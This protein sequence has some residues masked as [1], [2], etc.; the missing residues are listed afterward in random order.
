LI[1]VDSNGSLPEERISSLRRADPYRFI[2]IIIVALFSL[3][4]NLGCGKSPPQK[5]RELEFVLIEPGVFT[6]GGG[7]TYSL[8][9]HEVKITKRFYIGMTE[10]T[11]SQWY[12]VM[13][14]QPWDTRA[15]PDF[16]ATGMDW[17][18]AVEFCNRLSKRDGERHR[19]PTDAEWEYACRAGS[20]TAF[21]FYH[22]DDISML[23]DYAWVA[24]NAAD[25]GERYP[26]QVA[27][28]R[29][30]AWGLYDVH[31][32]V[33]EF[34]SDWYWRP[35]REEL[36]TRIDPTGPPAGRESEMYVGDKRVVRGGCWSSSAI[37]C[38]SYA[39]LRAKPESKDNVTGFRVV[40]EVSEP[41]SSE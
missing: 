15:G 36:G 25:V 24:Y 10:V 4:A 38:T 26:H 12:E 29:P 32:N 31:G 37:E 34:C 6:M 35:V 2:A 16:P 23:H 18:E 27:Q 22:E 19:L 33:Y 28:K 9:A 3:T 17:H 13:R 11:Q 20:K 40:K 8:P 7:D 30:N 1:P 21:C 41:A 5:G 14:T 39:R